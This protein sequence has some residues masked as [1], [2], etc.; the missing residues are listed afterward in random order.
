MS[1]VLKPT[2]PAPPIKIT[3]MKHQVVS[4][5]F[6]MKQKCMFDMSDPGTGKTY[7]QI[8][9]FAKRRKKNEVLL[10][11]APK[12]LLE[13]AWENDIAKFAPELRV[14]VAHAKNREEAFEVEADVYI[15]NTDAVTWIAKKPKKFFEHFNHIVIDEGTTFKHHT[16]QRSRAL[17]K[18]KAHFE[19]RSLLT[20]TPNPNTITDIW[21]QANFLDD[22]KRLGHSF[23]AFRNAVCIPKQVGSRKE[24]VEWQDKPGAEEVTF[25]LLA[26]ITIRHRFED[27][28][29]IP[30]NLQYTVPYKLTPKQMRAYQEMA[31]TQIAALGQNK[32][33]TAINAAAVATKLLQIASGA[34]YE[35]T[36]KYHLVDKGRYELVMDLVEERQH[37]L[38]FYLWQHQ[39]DL[40]IEEAKRR[41]LKY[42]VYD[43]TASD[44]TRADMIRDY[45]NGFY[46]VMFAHPQSAAHG[47]TLTRGTAT[48]W[49]SP[50]YNLEHFVQGNKRTYRNGQKSK[51]ETIVIIAPGTIEDKVYEKLQGKN[52]RM[53]NLLDLFT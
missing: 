37:S 40:L 5:K 50:T 52:V 19:Y 4:V 23:F 10:V 46:Q 32:A 31:L 36:G 42:C 28:I 15:T 18:I 6:G 47:L 3:A 27:C 8:A 22:G 39:R 35:H 44:K 26:D 34:V 21:N 38:V 49:P 14:S 17:N 29:D 48:I 11:I 12:S 43:S 25:A 33:I 45:Q 30:A 24:M 13:P 41:K 16:S 9:L 53:M 7:V 1:A 2:K 51:T 20:G